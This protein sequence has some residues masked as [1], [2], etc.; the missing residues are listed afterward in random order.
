MHLS[1]RLGTIALAAMLVG[2]TTPTTTNTQNTNQN[3]NTSTEVKKTVSGKVTRNGM[4]NPKVILVTVEGDSVADATLAFL[5]IAGSTES[6]RY[7]GATV[8]KPNADDTYSFDL[9]LGSK[10]Y[11]AGM[12]MCWNDAND[13]GKYSDNEVTAGTAKT[14]SDQTKV[15]LVLSKTEYKEYV[16]T[17]PVDVKSAYNWAFP[18]VKQT[19]SL[20]MANIPANGKFALLTVEGNSDLE[21]KN[22][23]DALT[24]EANGVLAPNAEVVVPVAASHS[25]EIK[26]DKKPYK[27]VSILGWNDANN[28]GKIQTDELNNFPKATVTGSEASIAFRL[29][30]M[31]PE[32]LKVL[33]GDGTASANADAEY[34]WT[35]SNGI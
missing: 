8:L 28:D 20:K 1:S 3:N 2:C 29:S 32:N 6:D 7:P 16:N 13:D 27:G 12:V 18:E 35:F 10:A 25:L 21:L 23:I 22:A 15:D 34:T 33:T 5:N 31:Q 9:K 4:A 26:L 14:H 11:T 17:Q 30:S 24:V 19:V